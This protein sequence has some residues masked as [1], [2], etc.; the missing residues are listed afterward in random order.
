MKEQIEERVDFPLK[1][2]KS[3]GFALEMV[4]CM[5]KFGLSTEIGGNL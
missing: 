1:N 4:S 2:G 5:F 3:A